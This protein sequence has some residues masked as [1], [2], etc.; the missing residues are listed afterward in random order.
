M[1]MIMSICCNATVTRLVPAVVKAV[2]GEIAL[3]DVS[4]ALGRNVFVNACRGRVA[5]LA[6]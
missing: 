5:T 4:T 6:C 3:M 2:V 1:A